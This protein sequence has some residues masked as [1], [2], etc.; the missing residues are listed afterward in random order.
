MDSSKN[1]LSALI[2]Q[3]WTADE[4]TLNDCILDLFM[5]QVKSELSKDGADE[6]QIIA[7]GFDLPT[8]DVAIICVKVLSYRSD[9]DLEMYAKGVL[10]PLD[11]PSDQLKA[12]MLQDNQLLALSCLYQK[13]VDMKKV[14]EDALDIV[15]TFY[16][17]TMDLNSTDRVS[18]ITKQGQD[19]LLTQVE[20]ISEKQAEELKAGL[21]RH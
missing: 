6:F 17:R 2:G 9:E 21:H 12:T 4:K 13:D 1:L 18:M 10:M 19:Y 15:T 5:H 14:T 11:M 7:K 16:K 3:Y 8:A 20:R